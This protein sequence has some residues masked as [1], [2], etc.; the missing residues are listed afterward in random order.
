MKNKLAFL[1]MA[2]AFAIPAAVPAPVSAEAPYQA[3]AYDEWNHSKASPNGYL[4][5]R[6][7][8]GLDAGSGPFS[9][10]Q[11]LFVDGSD[12]IYVADSGNGRIVV[13][14]DRFREID[15]IS[16]VAWQGKKLPLKHPTG[17][18]AA[19]DGRLYV[20]DQDRVLRVNG[21]KEAELVI[22]KPSH[23]LIPSDFKFKPLK[24]AADA[25][26]RIYVLSEGQFFG[27]MQ[28]DPKGQF[29]GYFGSN[30]VEVT[31]YVVLETFWKSILTKAQREGMAKLLPIEYSNLDV[32]KDGFVYT[33]TIVSQNSREEIKKLNPLG[34]NVLTGENGIGD[35]GDKETAMKKGVKQDTS[36]VDLAVHPEGF[37]AGL[38]RTRGRVFEYDGDG[39]A[40]AV[41][42][43]LGNQQGTFQQPAAVAYLGD[44]LLVLDSGKRSITRFVPTEYGRTVHEAVKLYNRGLYK[45]AA[46]EWREASKRD[47]NNRQAYVGIAKALENE[48]KYAE[49]LPFFKLGAERGGYSDDYAQI[50][51]RSVRSHMPLIMTLLGVL[52]FGY[53]GAK[54]YRYIAGP[55]RRT[56][57]AKRPVL[58]RKKMNPFRALLHPFDAFYAVKAEGKGSLPFAGAIVAVFFFA[59]VFH[60]QNT[61]FIFN[62]HDLNDLN[63]LL[64]AAKT[65]VLY[66]LWVA[67][68]WAVATWME[69]EGKASEIAIVSAYSILP[70]VAGLILTTLLSNVLVK[71]EGVFLPYVTAVSLL[72]SGVLMLVGLLTIHD[73]GFVR[74]LRSVALTFAAM[75]IAVFLATLFYTLFQQAYVFASTIYNELLFRI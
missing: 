15:S 17:I 16:E 38:D 49:A 51:I 66:A 7:Y 50:R 4:P 28:F 73:Y 62:P 13:L 20:A 48:E 52:L 57:L 30:K 19:E 70:Y 1:A 56:R 47:L 34:N 32:G 68:N 75:G 21:N 5:E 44:D 55:N 58:F 9:E 3:Y 67:C 65:V 61:G 23:P 64:I 53:Y 72:W 35:F 8:S 31:P 36:F 14:D 40:V 59:S 25:A 18:F 60:R 63:V 37:I 29:M 26:G 6:T 24:V 27:L 41:F 22:E 10:P 45:E 42:G 33:T 69:G 11:D 2:L 71:E 12:R 39:N 46:A 54:W 74:T 43:G